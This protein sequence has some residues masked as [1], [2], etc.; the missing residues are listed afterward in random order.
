MTSLRHALNKAMKETGWSVADSS[1]SLIVKGHKKKS[2]KLT[3]PATVTEASKRTST[4]SGKEIKPGG[5]REGRKKIRAAS[6]EEGDRARLQ[7][8]ETKSLSSAA[9]PKVYRVAAGVV[10]PVGLTEKR[11]E[12]SSARPLIKPSSTVAKKKP[13][14]FQAQSGSVLTKPDSVPPKPYELKFTGE[15]RYIPLPQSLH[16]R[17]I[18][19]LPVELGCR[20][21]L[22]FNEDDVHDV[23]I[24]LDFGTSTVKVVVGDATIEKSFVVPFRDTSGIARYLLPCKLWE[25]KEKGVKKF[26]LIEGSNAFDDLKLSVL[27]APLNDNYIIQAA[28]FI[29]LVLKHV[30]AWLFSEYADI[31]QYTSIYWTVAIGLPSESHLD[32]DLTP[33]FGRIVGLAWQA[34][35]ETEVRRS[36]IKKLLQGESSGCDD[37]SIAV[38]PELAAQIHGFASSPSASFD[39]N[40]VN[41]YVIVDVGAG[42]VD[43]SVFQVEQK[44]G[45]WNFTYYTAAVQPNGVANLHVARINWW[46]DALSSSG[47]GRPIITAMRNDKFRSDLE[48]PIPKSYEQYVENIAVVPK[49]NYQDPDSNFFKKRLLRQ[50]SS[51]TVYRCFSKKLLSQTDITGMPMFLCG[52][53]SRMK[54][55]QQLK[56]E[57]QTTPGTTWLRL[58]PW[59][60]T[61]PTDL[62]CKGV[63][64]GDYDRLSVAYGLSRLHLGEI[65]TA[66][67]LPQE[68]EER[69]MTYQ[70]RYIDK[71]QV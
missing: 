7:E 49:N 65:D 3:H 50:V 55:Y 29:A 27:A 43:S 66:L 71:D 67:P 10:R 1:K 36:F 6:Q 34:S 21:Q 57:L 64:Q 52:G 8:T 22:T 2:R 62:I 53:G 63:A 13:I 28:G 24:G 17:K 32:N 48:Q 70:D 5:L 54:F 14:D 60:L 4:A 18:I 68:L 42:T 23:T 33:V 58:E 51:D 44:R 15:G 31:Y 45:L 46:I 20:T 47:R 38:I 35:Q 40:R 37:I 26:S 30:R 39:R 25:T 59:T 41:R 11:R 19:S 69:R 12:V 56:S 16:D 9:S 61:M